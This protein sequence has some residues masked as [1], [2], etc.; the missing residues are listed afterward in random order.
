MLLTDSAQETYS[1]RQIDLT[2]GQTVQITACNTLD[3]KDRLN[4]TDRLDVTGRLDKTY[5][6]DAKE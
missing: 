2:H 3:A 6:L 1:M 5:R 4:V